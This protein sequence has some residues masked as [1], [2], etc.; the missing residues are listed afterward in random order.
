M[1]YEGCQEYPQAKVP[2]P[3]IEFP[4]NV[5]EYRFHATEICPCFMLSLAV[6]LRN[7]RYVLCNVLPEQC[8]TDNV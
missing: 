1:Q 3:R 8:S 4:K 2:S 7:S 6:T 5:S